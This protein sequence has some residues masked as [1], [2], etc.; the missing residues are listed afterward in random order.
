MFGNNT[1]AVTFPVKT[2]P[3]DSLTEPHVVTRRMKQTARS[4]TLSPF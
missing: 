4:L 2:Q 1:T 3:F